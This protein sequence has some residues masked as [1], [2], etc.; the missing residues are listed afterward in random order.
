MSDPY[1]HIV[2]DLAGQFFQVREAGSPDLAHVFLGVAV[3][4]TKT[5]FEPKAK[6]R[7]F[8]VRKLGTRVVAV[9]AQKAA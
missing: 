7:E 4:R 1:T 9:L 5:G 3:K 8:S 6:A 2:Q